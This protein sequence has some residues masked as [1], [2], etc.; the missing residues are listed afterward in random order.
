MRQPHRISKKEAESLAV[1]AFAFIAE[2]GERIGPFLATSG[3]APDN[4]RAAAR[5][6]SFL[7]GVLDYLCGNEALL[8]EFAGNAGIDPISVALAR[9]AL[10][11][12]GR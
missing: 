7:L 11:R 3:L 9:D 1:Q 2:D 6:R 12:P 8:L 10:D 5:E 4:L